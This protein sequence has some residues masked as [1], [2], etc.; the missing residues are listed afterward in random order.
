MSDLLEI[1]ANSFATNLTHLVQGCISEAPSFVAI[2]AS[3]DRQRRIGPEPFGNEHGSSDGF[4]Y[5]PLIRECDNKDQPRLMLK[6]EF[7]VS[8]DSQVEHL[9]VQQS[10]FGL[11]VR[12]DPARKP[13]PV[14]RVEYDREATSKPCAHLHLHAE[15]VELGW[16]YG[17]EGLPL[18]RLQEIHFPVGGRRFRPTVEELLEF[19]DREKLFTNWNSDWKKALE[20]SLA[21]WNKQQ[22]QATVRNNPETA[23]EQ[24]EKMR[25]QVAAFE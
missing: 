11:W 2:N 13:R 15:S 5:V 19:L 4:S 21:L 1:E 8:L 3:E 24:L 14:F 18:P 10:T 16:V 7:R 12:P 22:V 20:Q 17:T 25:Y 9:A 6:I 23:I